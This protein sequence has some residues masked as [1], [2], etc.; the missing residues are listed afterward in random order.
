MLLYVTIL[1]FS[2]TLPVE[3]SSTNSSEGPVLSSKLTIRTPSA[4]VYAKQVVPSKTP[5]IDGSID[6]IWANATGLS[7]ETEWG[8]NS[9]L[10]FLHDNTNLYILA[11]FDAALAWVS[12]I[13]AGGSCM[14]TDVDLWE[15]GHS[16]PQVDYYSTGNNMPVADAIDDIKAGTSIQDSQKI[17]EM[18]RALLTND[19]AGFDIH[20]VIGE[21]LT[22]LVGSSDA[23][24]SNY[25]KY[26]FEAVSMDT[27]I[28][29]NNPSNGESDS[30][31]EIEFTDFVLVVSLAMTLVTIAIHMVVRVFLRPIKHENRVISK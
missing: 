28:E 5:T 4:D 1:F 3:V 29:N 26:S 11:V 15:F 24:Y 10:K 14:P 27:P 22:F 21:S 2:L 8:S 31:N 30:E 17:V 20:F 9:F 16:H 18:R 23:H 13:W 7:L 12:I 25:G 6:Q 19:T